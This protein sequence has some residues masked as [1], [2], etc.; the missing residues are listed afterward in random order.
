M[1]LCKGIRNLKNTMTDHRQ[2]EPANN[3]T[4]PKG[5]NNLAIIFVVI[6]IPLGAVV[7]FVMLSEGGTDPN[8]I[9]KPSGLKYVE[10][11]DG[12]G[13]EAKTGDTVTVHYTGTFKD[14][15]KFDSSLDRN[16]PFIFTLGAG[17]VIK[18]WDE[19]VVGMKVGGQRKLIVP[20]DLAY[21]PKGRGP[22]PPKAELTFV[23][24]LLSVK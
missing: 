24:E 14:G 1:I 17:E 20:Y 10:L 19:G 8:A 16:E 7:L 23:V 22:I 15:K 12:K 2:N 6:L 9:T 18:G 11:K 3:Q 4:T 5:A 21:G 13:Q